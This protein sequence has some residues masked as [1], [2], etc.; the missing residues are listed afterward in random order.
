V[1][2][3]VLR[4]NDKKLQPK[5]W[6]GNTFTVISNLGMFGIDEFTAIINTPDSCIMAVGGIDQPF[7]WCVERTDR[8][9][10]RDAGN[11]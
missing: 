11:P 9:W 1:K 10:K 8:S 7:L 6:E 5:D 4:A 3:F 2:D